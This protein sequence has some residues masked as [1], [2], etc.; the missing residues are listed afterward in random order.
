MCDRKSS[1][2][3]GLIAGAA[4][5][6]G[7][8]LFLQTDQ[9]KKVKKELAKKAEPY[10]DDLGGLLEDLKDQS[11]EL[12]EKAEEVKTTIEEKIV[13]GKEEAQEVLTDKL[14]NSLTHIEELQERGREATATIR[15]KFFKNIKKP[16]N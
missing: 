5:G 6:I 4:I 12:L 2:L 3:E 9:G 10:L 15:K 8:Y 1:F 11:S 7:G 14:E 16:A 13:E